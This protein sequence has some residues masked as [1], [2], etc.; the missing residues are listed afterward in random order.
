M[1]IRFFANQKDSSWSMSKYQPI[2]LKTALEPTT[3]SGITLALS[4]HRV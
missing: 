2:C 4:R 1:V 3:V